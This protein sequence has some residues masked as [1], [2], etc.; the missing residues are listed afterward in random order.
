MKRKG[1]H[2]LKIS[3]LKETLRALS[4]LANVSS[5]N[6]VLT[7]FDNPLTNNSI[8]NLVVFPSTILKVNFPILFNQIWPLPMILTKFIVVI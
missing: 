6:V 3:N 2:V 8:L 4:N 7:K 5:K 1:T